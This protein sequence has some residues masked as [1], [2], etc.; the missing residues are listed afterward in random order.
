MWARKRHDHRS[1]K[2]STRNH[3]DHRFV[4]KLMCSL[5]SSVSG[6]RSLW[7]WPVVLH[8]R[9]DIAHFEHYMCTLTWVSG[10]VSW[11][12]EGAHKKT[13]NL[14]RELLLR[15]NTY[16]LFVSLGFFFLY[17]RVGH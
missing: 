14:Q 15:L 9:S 2:L 5:R 8:H 7:A 17:Q 10:L 6:R 12:R 11:D 16:L 4:P 3:V 13:I 1:H